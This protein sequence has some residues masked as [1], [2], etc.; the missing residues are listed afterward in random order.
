MNE[1]RL[2]R[3]A[4]LAV[5]LAACSAQAPKQQATDAEIAAMMPLKRQ[6]SDVVMGFD[7][8]PQT[9][10]IVSV[11]LRQYILTDDDTLAAIRRDA[12]ARWRA[13]WIAAHPHKHAVLQV[14]FIDFVGG[15]VA[16]E[17]TKV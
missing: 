17:T 15:K 13:A 2:F 7:I 9:T 4:A 10:L 3:G 8:R 1:V 6:Y 11:D 14:R 12:L 5:L 16:T